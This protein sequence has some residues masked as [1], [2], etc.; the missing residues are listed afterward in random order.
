M[1]DAKTSGGQQQCRRPF[2]GQQ[3][4]LRSERRGQRTAGA[5]VAASAAEKSKTRVTQLTFPVALPQLP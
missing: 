3:R 5:E 4:K 2:P 1:G